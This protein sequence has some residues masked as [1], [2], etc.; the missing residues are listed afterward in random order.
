MGI[1]GAIGSYRN[2]LWECRLDS[3]GS[4]LVPVASSCEN[5]DEP[6][7]SIKGGEW[8]DQLSDY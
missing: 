7:G 1:E 4:G 2:G 6:S 3:S 5:G 8:F